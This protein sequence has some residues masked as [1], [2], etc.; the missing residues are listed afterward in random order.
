MKTLLFTGA[1][2]F[3]GSNVRP[4]QKELKARGLWN[5]QIDSEIEK[6]DRL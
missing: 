2:G 4:L 6:R 5:R 1:T 3:L